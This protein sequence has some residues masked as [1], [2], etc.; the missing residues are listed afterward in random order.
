LAVP[1]I[2]QTD[3]EYLGIVSTGFAAIEYFSNYGNVI[4]TD[5][6]YARSLDRNKN[7]IA[8]ADR[9]LLGKNF[10]TEQSQQLIGRNAYTIGEQDIP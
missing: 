5:A 8:I 2:R 6:E 7:Y 10:F 4:D 3:G 1:I 9:S